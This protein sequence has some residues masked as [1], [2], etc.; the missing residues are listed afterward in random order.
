MRLEFFDW[1][2]F[3]VLDTLGTGRSGAVFK[4][5]LHGELVALKVCDLW[6]HP[7]YKEELLNEVEVYHALTD[8]QGQC[9]P[10]LKGAGY[11]AGG[12]F[13]IATEIVGRRL[14]D[15]ERLTD[16]EC[17]VIQRALSRVHDHGFAH[18]DIRKENILIK[19]NGR[20]FH[21]FLIDFAFSK[22]GSPCDF[23]QERELLAELLR[24]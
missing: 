15:A 24:L 21:A 2:S 23:E 19:R 16:M 20:Q 4:A 7:D 17:R 6:Q 9:I 1:D 18:N 22:R 14:E 12:L 3:R 8:L 10:R 13:V 5:S 11:T